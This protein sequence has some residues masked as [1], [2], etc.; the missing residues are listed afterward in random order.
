[1]T[2]KIKHETV[3]IIFDRN[4]KFYRYGFY[5]D[6]CQL[7]ADSIKGFIRVVSDD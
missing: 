5:P 3:V 2:C 6:Q 4:G 7:I 1:M